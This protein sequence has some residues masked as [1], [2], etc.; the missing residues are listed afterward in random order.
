[1]QIALTVPARSRPV[2][3]AS[4]V[5]KVPADVQD[6]ALALALAAGA[7][8]EVIIRGANDAA[9][10]ILVALGGLALLAR[11]RAPWV[12]MSAI[13]VAVLARSAIVG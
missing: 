11:R 12:M 6:A 5:R 7:E 4:R 9:T 8:A 1:M 13:L 2:A 10:L 3:W